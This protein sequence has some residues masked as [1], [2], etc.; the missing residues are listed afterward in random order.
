MTGIVS[1]LFM[2][3]LFILAQNIF[4]IIALPEEIYFMDYG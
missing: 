2:A 1:G 4:G 3:L